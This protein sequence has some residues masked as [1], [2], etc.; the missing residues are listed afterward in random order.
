MQCCIGPPQYSGRESSSWPEAVLPGKSFFWQFHSDSSNEDWGYLMY[1]T[2]VSVGLGDTSQVKC[3]IAKASG[4][5]ILIGKFLINCTIFYHFI[6][7]YYPF[8]YCFYFQQTSPPKEIMKID[9]LLLELFVIC[10]I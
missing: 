3:D 2:A 8:I 9:K 6:M 1:V 5:E 7:L 4:A 10:L